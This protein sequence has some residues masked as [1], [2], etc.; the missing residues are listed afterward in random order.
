[1]SCLSLGFVEQL[2]VWLIIVV[3]VVAVIKLLIP[4]LDGLTGFPIVGQ[5]ISIL[6]WAIVAIMI[7]YVIFGLLSCLVGSGPGL[8]LPR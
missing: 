7:L 3:A 2:L 8:H 5:I 1:M 6:L 4:F